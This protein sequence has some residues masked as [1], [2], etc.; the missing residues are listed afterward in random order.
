MQPTVKEI[1]EFTDPATE[2]RVRHALEFMWEFKA[3]IES[4]EAREEDPRGGDYWPRLI[5]AFERW[6]R[7]R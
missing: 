2:P 6:E 3:W 1:D 7:L 5:S 4:P